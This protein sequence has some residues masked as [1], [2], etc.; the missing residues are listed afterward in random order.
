MPLAPGA[1][2]GP[3]EITAA[4][5]ADGRDEVQDLPEKY[6]VMQKPAHIFVRFDKTEAGGFWSHL[7][8]RVEGAEFVHES[9]PTVHVS[10]PVGNFS[11][12]DSQFVEVKLRLSKSGKER[13]FQIPRH[14][15]IMI[16]EG[17]G[18]EAFNFAPRIKS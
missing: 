11:L 9:G 4:F 15:V 16:L 13:V 17:H 14:L 8:D 7:F 12:T 1:R 3:Y 10:V 2:F 5:G 6:N 18:K